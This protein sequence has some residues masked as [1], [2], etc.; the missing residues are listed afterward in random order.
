MRKKYILWIGF[1][2]LLLALVIAATMWSLLAGEMKIQLSQ[3][4]SI[5]KNKTGMEYAILS[6]I[7]IPRLLLAFSIGG[8]LS[9][10]GAILQGIYRNPLVEPYTLGISGGASLGVTIA[11]VCGLSALSTMVLP[12]FG[13]A[14]AF[15]TIFIV[16]IDR[17]S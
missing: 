9:I 7:R 13:F 10:T 16:Y 15:V 4:P 14:G 11:I 8:A 2:L 5:L 3:L 12:L 6:N 17:K 1:V